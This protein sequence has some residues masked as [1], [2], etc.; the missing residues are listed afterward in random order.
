MTQVC[1]SLFQTSCH[2]GFNRHHDFI[3]IVWFGLIFF[4]LKIWAWTSCFG[5]MISWHLWLK[6]E[7]V[8]IHNQWS[9]L[10]SSD[11]LG[12]GSQPNSWTTQKV[13]IEIPQ[14]LI[15][16]YDCVYTSAQSWLI[17]FLPLKTP[18]RSNG[19]KKPPTQKLKPTF[20]TNIAAPTSS[21]GETNRSF[22]NR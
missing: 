22:V 11:L 13:S 20:H 17:E 21:S 2:D 18:R 4:T 3:K 16:N 9:V 10:L 5:V 6:S 7:H 12:Y 19:H 1:D 15:N 14:V 8:F